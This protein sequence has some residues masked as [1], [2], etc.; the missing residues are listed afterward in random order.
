MSLD[1]P[2]SSE[3]RTYN[4]AVL[5]FLTR[6]VQNLFATIFATVILFPKTSVSAHTEDSAVKGENTV[7]AI[8][9]LCVYETQRLFL[10]AT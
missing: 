8:N 3:K 4:E 2:V 5:Y 9:Q 10:A 1:E 7:T 6:H